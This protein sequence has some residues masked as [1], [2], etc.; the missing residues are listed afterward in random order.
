[1]GNDALPAAEKVLILLETLASESGARGVA[2]LSR[3]CGLPKS[4]THR[5]LQVLRKYWLAD[6]CDGKYQPASRLLDLA[7]L[8]CVLQP[9]RLRVLVHP[10]LQE[11]Y[12]LTRSVVQL[13]V[14]RGDFVVTADSLCG[15]ESVALAL[16][17]VE[18]SHAANTVSGRTLLAYSARFSPPSMSNRRG[19]QRTSKLS[20]EIEGIR[21]R[22]FGVGRETGNESIH[23]VAAPVLDENLQAVAVISVSSPHGE[24]VSHVATTVR[25]AAHAASAHLASTVSDC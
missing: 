1:M 8:A 22:G 21:R 4:T 14:L 20:L 24:V 12:A 3:K 6:H 25:V 11:L 17:L 13:N 5:L 16:R 9:A 19:R 15:H 23:T 2:E 18:R 7:E 10:W